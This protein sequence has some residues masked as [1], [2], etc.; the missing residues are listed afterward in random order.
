MRLAVAFVVV[1][2]ADIA[3]RG[4]LGAAFTFDFFSILF[5]IENFSLL[6]PA[7]VLLDRSRRETPRTAFLSAIVVGLGA[8]LYRF[9]PTDDLLRFQAN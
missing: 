5:H 2:Y 7:A 9:V 6:I 4:Q 1:R 3:Y 8:M